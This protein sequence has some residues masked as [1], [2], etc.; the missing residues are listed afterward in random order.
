MELQQVPLQSSIHIEHPAT[1]TTDKVIV[2]VAPSAQEIE[3]IKYSDIESNDSKRHMLMD[4]MDG[5][6]DDDDESVD[7]SVSLL[8]TPKP[9]LLGAKPT[10]DVPIA[11]T[12]VAAAFSSTI[13]T[14]T[15]ISAVNKFYNNFVSTYV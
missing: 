2:V 1:S 3:V 15:S 13:A 9:H 14:P 4:S 7:Q 6:I 11:P 8:A 10:M 5:E 12:S